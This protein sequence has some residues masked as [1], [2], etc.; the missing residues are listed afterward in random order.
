VADT[1]DEVVAEVENLTKRYGEI[2]AVDGVSFV[3]HRGEIFGMV[4]PNGVARLR[5]SLFS[6][7]I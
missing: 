3:V 2:V 1:R 4:S 5:S 6:G 7:V